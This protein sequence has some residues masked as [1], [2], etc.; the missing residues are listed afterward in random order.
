MKRK[1]EQYL[2][3][4]YGPDLTVK[5]LDGHYEYTQED[6]GPLLEFIRMKLNS[7][8]Y[9][10]KVI[11]EHAA[12]PI[13]FRKNQLQTAL[14]IACQQSNIQIV[15]KLLAQGVDVNAEDDVSICFKYLYSIM[16]LINMHYG[17]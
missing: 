4:K 13:D 17:L 9:E 7:E 15:K 16:M 11:D 6:V 5:N 1:V 8:K 3:N 2:K 14:H 12:R 10:I